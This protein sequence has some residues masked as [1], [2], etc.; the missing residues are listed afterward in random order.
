MSTPST[1]APSLAAGKAVV[2]SPH[3]RSST[4]SPFVT[5]SVFTSASP[6]SLLLAAIRV[7]SPFSHSALFG[8]I[9]NS[10]RATSLQRP[11]DPDVSH[12]RT[13]DRLTP[14]TPYRRA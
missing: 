1:F 10:P 5:S 11:L 3:P 6:L 12:L 2:P 8:F 13:A 14:I 9:E 4:L 7:Q